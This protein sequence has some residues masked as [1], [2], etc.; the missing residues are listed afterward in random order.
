MLPAH[1]APRYDFIICGSGSAGSVV[2][3]RTAENP[4]V[5]VLLIEAGGADDAPEVIDPG[6]WPNNLGSERDWA[7]TAEPSAHVNGRSI[8]LAMGKVLGGGSSIN[9]MAW[10]RGH[11]TDWDFFATEA[12]DDAWSYQS[13]L[14]IYRRIE[15]WDG[16]CDAYY[17]GVG[18]PVYVRPAADP[19]PIASAILEGARAAGIPSYGSLNGAM[20]ERE[21][22][23]SIVELRARGKRRQ[24]VFGSYVRPHLDRPN[25]TVLTGATVTRVTFSGN[26]ATG[27]EFT[28]GEST[29]SVAAA[30]EVIVSLGAINTP[31]LLMQSGVGDADV[32]RGF[33][34]PVVAHLPGVGDN[35]QDHPRIDCVW[36]CTQ[37]LVPRNNG[38]EAMV[39]WRSD[40]AMD[41]PDVQICLAE[42]PIASAENAAIYAM[43]EHGWSLCAG[44]IRP[45]SRGR[46]RLTGPRPADPVAIE[47][48][49]LADTDDMTAAVAAVE[50]SREIGNSA[51]LRPFVKREVMPGDLT[52]R[53][54]EHFIRNAA[55]TYWH[56]ASTAKMG[57]DNMS[58]VDGNLKVYGLDRLR[59]ADG[60]IMPRVT[61]GNTMAP[62][63]II[64]ERAADI[65]KTA[66]SL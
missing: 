41:T 47:A 40:S 33:G 45:K 60:S 14:D 20:M 38:A 36:E 32:L 54:L 17:R 50:L 10:A 26:E 52:G 37:P 18:G 15:D 6:L 3:A 7:F 11:K 56:H 12:A 66:H 63:V 49:M 65:V 59:I 28:H 57:R 51:S 29:Y 9:V 23:A 61:T 27:I 13:V 30:C 25:L 46:V 22:G 64:G 43:P 16:T 48:N 21:G 39:F 2:A 8:E 44:V 24:S 4:G 1:V 62:C 55:E 5:S 31:K 58:V 19:N 42:F 35:F 53:E 34:I